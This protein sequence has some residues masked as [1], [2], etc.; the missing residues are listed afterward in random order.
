[1]F[2]EILI[3]MAV[4]SLLLANAERMPLNAKSGQCFTKTF[5]PP[6]YTKTTHIK[7]T[8]KILLNDASVKYEVIPAKFSWHEERVQVSDEKEKII[9]KPA[10]YKT[11][12]KRI[13]VKPSEKIWRRNLSLNSPKAFNSCVDSASSAGM[14]I[15]NATVGTCFYEHYQPK[16]YRATTAKILASETS[17]RIIVT[18]AKYRVRSKK[19]ITDST[20]AKLLPSVAVYK[21]VKDKVAVEPAHTEWKKTTCQNRGCNQSEVVCLIEVPVKY[22]ELT[23]RVVL[24][25]AVEKRVAV[26][27]KYKTLKVEER[28]SPASEQRIAIPARYKRITKQE[29]VSEEKHFWSDEFSKNASTRL[30]SECNK[31]CLTQTPAKY[32]KVAQQVVVT[33]ASSKKIIIPKKYKTV[34][35]KKIYQKASFKKVVIPAEYVTVITERERTKGYSKWMPMVCESNMTPKIIKKVQQALKSEGF[36]QGEVDGVWDIESKSSARAYQKSKGLGITS[37]LSIE[38]M[39]ALGIF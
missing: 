31:I 27:P 1:M 26:T 22:K 15:E 4:I 17:E 37:K 25:P 32:R 10:V 35:V 39:M 30:R 33:P 28:I 7:S 16:K 34:R 29:K 23:K 20:T 11:I 9:V 5:Y 2:K 21:K 6:E 36:Y 19:I 14:D 24:E 3:I 38:T 18:P 12:Y 8:K 13:L